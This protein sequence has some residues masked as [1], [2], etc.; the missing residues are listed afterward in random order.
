MFHDNPETMRRA[1]DYIER[2]R[3]LFADDE[4]LAFSRSK[5]MEAYR[6]CEDS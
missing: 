2:W 5:A 4:L 1:A 6:K 3:A